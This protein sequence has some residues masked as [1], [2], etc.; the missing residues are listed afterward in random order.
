M[1]ARV[2]WVII[3]AMLLT[4]CSGSAGANQA[5]PTVVLPSNGAA[6]SQASDGSPAIPAGSV[7]AS[8]VIV[9]AQEAQLAFAVGGQIDEVVVAVGDEVRAGQVLAR[10][11]G[12]EPLKAAVSEADLNLL[13]A[14]QALDDFMS[15]PNWELALAEAQSDLA[16]AKDELRTADYNRTV[17]QPG[18][19][20][21]ALTI[22]SAEAKL[23]LAKEA[24]DNAK[25]SYDHYADHPS[26]DPRRAA[27]LTAYSNAQTAYNSALRTV[28]WYKGHPTDLQQSQFDA[29][30]AV[31]Q[32]KV[33][34]AQERVDKLQNGP[35]PD[36]AAVLKG[37]L[38]SA[39]DQV[40]AARAE[41]AQ[42]ELK[43]PFDGNVGKI[44]AH[45]GEWVS[46]GQAAVVIA[47]LGHLRVE[48]TD[49]SE[50]DVP[51]VHVGQSASINIKALNTSAEAT[52]RE[53]SPL[54]DTLGGDVVYQTTL[55][56]TS[57]PDGLKPGMSVDVQFLGGG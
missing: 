4:G 51:A 11:S 17:N 48:T 42:L 32:A 27:A 29:A 28:N 3:P 56:L 30:V 41:L 9:P 20:A 49:L 46:S 22:E 39:Q 25:S 57:A 15:D 53:I 21:S 44:L 38:T 43:A 7:T 34:Q 50:R 45:A 18:Y 55:D 12:G 40:A 1:N 33:D 5:L 31:A 37:Q 54:A 35:D 10:L 8:G 13:K 36:Q 14:Q 52:V 19:R 23:V 2:A 16:A 26:D 47:D 6:P 24:L